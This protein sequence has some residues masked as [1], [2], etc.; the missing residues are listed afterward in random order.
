MGLIKW[1]LRA[2]WLRATQKSLQTFSRSL[3]FGDY[4]SDRWQRAELLGFGSG[5]TI[6][7]SSIVIGNVRVGSGTWIGPFVVLDGSGGLEIGDT[8]SISAG[9]Q[10]YTHDTVDWAISKGEAV[11]KHAPVTIGDGCY[12][13]PNAVIARGVT[14][15]PGCI[16]GANSFVNRSVPAGARVWGVPARTQDP[17]HEN[18]S[19][20][21]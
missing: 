14:L 4:V 1:L 11:P 18:V 6:Y 5:S 8:C 21:S 7:D 20:S 15:G 9:V 2:F 16:V 10:I 3:P 13:G 19:D 12:I 17:A